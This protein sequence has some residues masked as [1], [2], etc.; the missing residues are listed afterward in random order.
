MLLTG[1]SL[2]TQ[3]HT[4]KVRGWKK[5]FH[6]NNQESTGVAVPRSDHTD[7]NQNT[8]KRQ[9]E[10]VLIKEVKS[11]KRYKNHKHIPTTTRA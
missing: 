4:V 5:V 10:C 6:T 9:R 8:Y 1:D 11:T 2:Q 3:R 7:F